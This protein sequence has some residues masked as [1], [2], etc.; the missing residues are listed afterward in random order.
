M[1]KLYNK[2]YMEH[3]AEMKDKYRKRYWTNLLQYNP[4][5]EKYP[6]KFTRGKFIF[7]FT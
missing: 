1:V 2:Y 6:I 3:Y 4:Q 7:T 5:P